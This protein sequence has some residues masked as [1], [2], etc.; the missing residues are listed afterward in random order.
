MSL[1][2]ANPPAAEPALA[3]QAPIVLGHAAGYACART[4]SLGLRKGLIAALADNG[5]LTSDELADRLGMD[6][7]Y[8]SVW[9]QGAVAASICDRTGDRIA[10]A[11]HMATLLLDEG[12]PAFAGGVFAVLEQ[13]EVFGRFEAELGSGQRMWWSDCSNEWIASVGRTGR[14]FYTR[15]VPGAI[16]KVPGLAEKLQAGCRVADTACGAGVGLVRLAQTYPNCSV[17]GIDGDAYSLELAKQRLGEA[18]LDLP[19]VHSPL[20]DMT[21]DEP[22]AVVVNNIS[23]HECR[24]RDAVT[25]R[26]WDMLEP[27]GCFVIS[28]FPFPDSTAGLRSTPGRVMSGIQ[29]FEAQIDDQLLPR[30][31][32]D[33]LLE[34]HGFT[35][36]GSIEV[37]PMHAVTY[38][39]RQ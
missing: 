35:G 20:E 36:I 14:P 28:D 9:C 26:V 18:G 31:V 38:G 15:L 8:V 29:H 30:K 22:V 25:R 6:P 7:F 11:P 33:E 32:Y 39:F 1:P 37:T 23:M 12:S 10:L 3:D 17:I 19:L 5:G 2:T 21:L 13:P 4:I 16:E 34:R 27:G 24:D